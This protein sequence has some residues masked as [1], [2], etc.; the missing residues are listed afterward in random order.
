MTNDASCARK[1]GPG[2][3]KPKASLRA[4]RASCVIPKRRT[5]LFDLDNTLHHASASS[6]RGIDVRMTDYI[7]QHV[8]VP[9]AEANR[10]RAHYLHHYG[11]TLL[12]L[13]RH[14]G[15]RADHFLHETHQ[16]PGLE[17]TLRTHHADVQAL[18][19]LPGRKFILTNAPKAYALRVMRALGLHRHVQGIVSIEDMHHFGQLRPK[20]D[21]RM[22]KVIAARLRTTPAQCVLVEDTLIH[23]KSA[24]AV[25]MKTVWMQRW[26]RKSAQQVTYNGRVGVYLHRTP[27]YVYAKINSLQALK[28]KILW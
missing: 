4:Q 24:H 5:W 6:F 25:G 21:A 20:P 22:F 13:V 9:R 11:A 8:G 15:V 23:Q 18:A 28:K 17:A 19:R 12:G 2:P 3:S 26:L 1:L 7:E 16:L 27:E 10:L 14:H